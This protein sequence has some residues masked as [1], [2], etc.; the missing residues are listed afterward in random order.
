MP[1]YI[2]VCDTVTTSPVAPLETRHQGVTKV[3]KNAHI[4]MWLKTA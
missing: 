2:L 3:A 1:F 4:A